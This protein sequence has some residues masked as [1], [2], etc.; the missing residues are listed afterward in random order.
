MKLSDK[1]FQRIV[2][3]CNIEL[4]YNDNCIDKIMMKYQAIRNLNDTEYEVYYNE[5]VKTLGL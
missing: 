5:V 4:E 1:L 2:D 3:K